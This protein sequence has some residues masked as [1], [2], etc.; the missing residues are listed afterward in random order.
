M[1]DD[2]IVTLLMGV[3]GYCNEIQYFKYIFSSVIFLL[4]KGKWIALL[5]NDIVIVMWLYVLCRGLICNISTIQPVCFRLFQNWLGN[6]ANLYMYTYYS[7]D[8]TL[9]RSYLCV[10]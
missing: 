3:F 5:F 10:G 1:T 9:S 8:R 7:K 4:T 6:N 2:T